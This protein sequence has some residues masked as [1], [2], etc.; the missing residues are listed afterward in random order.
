MTTA[1][2]FDAKTN[3]SK[4]I[5]SILDKKEPYVIIVKNGKPVAKLVPYEN[6][7]ENRIGIGKEILKEMP[8]LDEF[9]QV[10][11]ESDFLGNE[12]LI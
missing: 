11:T 7:T 5:A 9:N 10:D 6:E 8:S 1:S 12:G 4:Y 3:L 2:I